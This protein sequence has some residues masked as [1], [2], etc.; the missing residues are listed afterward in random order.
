MYI[1]CLFQVLP[2]FTSKQQQQ[3]DTKNSST[4]TTTRYMDL[5]TTES[6]MSSINVVEEVNESCVG[7][8]DKTQNEVTDPCTAEV[9]G[10]LLI[11]PNNRM[12]FKVIKNYFLIRN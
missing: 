6:S 9:S 11:S 1:M 8:T 12:L 10:I 4:P 7:S 2:H 5:S 3:I